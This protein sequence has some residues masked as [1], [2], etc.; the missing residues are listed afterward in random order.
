MAGL[1]FYATFDLSHG[2]WQLPLERWAQVSQSFITPDGI[3]LRPASCM[4][5][6]MQSYICILRWDRNFR[7][8]C[9]PSAFGSSMI[10]YF[11]PERYTNIWMPWDC[12]SNF[13]KS[14]TSSFIWQTVSC[15]WK[16]FA[17]AV[18]RFRPTGSVKW[19]LQRP[20]PICIV[21]AMQWMRNAIPNFSAVIRSLQ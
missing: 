17:G 9:D 6:R 8:T 15:S 1:R 20:A 13:A 2:Y 7:P 10:C 16:A 12:F 14:L 5:R 19:P 3:A 4:A 18:V 11:F 21:C